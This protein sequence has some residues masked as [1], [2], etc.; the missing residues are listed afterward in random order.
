MDESLEAQVARAIDRVLES[1]QLASAAIAE[2]ERECA[3]AI[4]EARAARRSIL[5]R[6]RQR[7]ITLH[8]RCNQ[9]IEQRL[10]GTSVEPGSTTPAGE[11]GVPAPLRRRQALERLALALTTAE[12]EP[13][14][15]AS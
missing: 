1:E 12:P 5:D 11:A 4:E 8:A 9:I 7:I 3:A 2:C 14:N 6:A 15:D 10:A 13:R